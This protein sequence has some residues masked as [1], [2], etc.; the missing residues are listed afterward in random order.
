MEHTTGKT[1]NNC[2]SIAGKIG[3]LQPFFLPL[4]SAPPPLYSL[5]YSKIPVDVN[6]MAARWLPIA[7]CTKP[8]EC[9]CMQKAVTAY[10]PTDQ[11]YDAYKIPQRLANE[12]KH[13]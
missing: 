3:S 12:H 10:M 13:P 5:P 1:A 7:L 8:E 6:V 9:I 11:P 4:C 2:C